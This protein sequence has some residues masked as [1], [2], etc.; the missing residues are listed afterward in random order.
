MEEESIAEVPALPVLDEDAVI[1]GAEWE[2]A[3]GEKIEHML[4]L[5]TWKSG[6]DLPGLLE[7]LDREIGEALSQEDNLQRQIRDL[8]FPRIGKQKGAPKNAGVYQATADQLDRVY[9]K[10]LFNGGVEAC[11]GTSLVHDTLPMTIIQ[12]G[13][14]LVSYHGEQGSWIQRFYRRDLRVRGT[15]IVDE[16]LKIL[17]QR[18]RKDSRGKPLRMKMTELSKRGIMAYAERAALL[19]KCTAPWRMGQGNPAPY[20]LLTGSGSPELIEQSL[21]IL[22]ELIGHIKRFVFIPSSTTNVLIQTIGQALRPLEFAIV[23]T[24]AHR[25]GAL[26]DRGHYR[27]DQYRAQKERLDAFVQDLGP[28][29]VVGVYRA[30]HEAPAQVFY[31]HEEHAQ[32]AALI[33][34]AD[35]ALQAHRGFPMLID[36]ADSIC[37]G[38]FGLDGFNSSIQSAYAKHG[39]PLR[40]LGEREIRR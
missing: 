35:S 3:Y 27:G 21:P 28:Q 22:E 34:M 33:A 29:I 25:I 15:D 2:R 37:S 39:Q 32:E 1:S 8:L 36:I 10:I 14:C 6:D 4:N 26:V 5:D 38:A 7:R 9:R 12:I 18:E 20:E 11:D 16:A 23:D 30:T 40:Y 17:G 13:V 19:Q 24:E 31:A